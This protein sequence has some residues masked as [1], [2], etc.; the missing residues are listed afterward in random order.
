[1][2]SQIVTPSPGPPAG[3]CS[4]FFGV[5]RV[6][7]R[8]MFCARYRGS[9]ACH[10]LRISRCSLVGH[11]LGAKLRPIESRRTC[12]QP[13]QMC[14]FS[15]FALGSRLRGLARVDASKMKSSTLEGSME[16]LQGVCN[17]PTPAR[18]RVPLG[19]CGKGAGNFPHHPRRRSPPG[20]HG[21]QTAQIW[22]VLWTP[23]F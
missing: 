5:C 1:M 16:L 15:G 4:A 23:H 8:F 9:Q 10:A 3:L 14:V 2:G 22:A 18:C 13:S 21:F 17:A 11:S 19:C 6:P 20:C 7:H 12:C